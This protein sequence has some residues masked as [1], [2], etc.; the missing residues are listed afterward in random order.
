MQ[1]I[2]VWFGSK[3]NVVLSIKCCFENLFS[4]D[5]VTCIH[6]LELNDMIYG[7]L[8]SILKQL[9]IQIKSI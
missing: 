5:I 7:F 1:N 8:K 9:K 4:K 2:Y 6:D 3:I